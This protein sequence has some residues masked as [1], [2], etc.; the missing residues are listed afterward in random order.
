MFADPTPYGRLEF[1]RTAEW[2]V[3]GCTA[4]DTLFQ[5]RSDTRLLDCNVR[6]ELEQIDHS[7]GR[8]STDGEKRREIRFWVIEN[9][10]NESTTNHA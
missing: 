9:C 2:A 3:D 6:T 10:V 8:Q 1:I 5:G 4:G 7:T